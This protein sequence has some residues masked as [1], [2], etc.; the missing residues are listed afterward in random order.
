MYCGKRKFI[1][2]LSC[3]LKARL[4]YRDSRPDSSRVGIPDSQAKSGQSRLNRDGWTLYKGFRVIRGHRPPGLQTAGKWKYTEIVNLT[5]TT[6]FC[7][8]LNILRSHQADLFGSW[9]EGVRAH[10]AHPL[11]TGLYLKLQVGSGLGCTN[12]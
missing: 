8:I 4:V 11:P 6:L 10:P 1:Q 9:G 12:K 2:V 3:I 5:I 7:I